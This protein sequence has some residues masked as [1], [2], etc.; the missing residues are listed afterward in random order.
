MFVTFTIAGA[1]Q[2]IVMYWQAWKH[3]DV[4]SVLK[5]ET[6]KA[7]LWVSAFQKGLMYFIQI[8]KI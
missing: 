8:F 5:R 4:K 3:T 2:M 1:L 6:E 7:I